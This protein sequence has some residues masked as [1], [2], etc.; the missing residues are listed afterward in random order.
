MKKMTKKYP[1]VSYTLQKTACR[2]LDLYRNDKRKKSGYKKKPPGIKLE[3]SEHVV[4]FTLII[5][6]VRDEYRT[7]YDEARGGYGK[8]LANKIRR[9]S[10]VTT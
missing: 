6:Q 5:Q 2:Y 7:D 4:I 9:S 10:D 3:N 1:D 8:M